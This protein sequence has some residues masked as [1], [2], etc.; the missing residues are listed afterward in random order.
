MDKR[1]IDPETG[2]M[3][4]S[5]NIEDILEAKNIPSWAR[6]KG[7]NLFERVHVGMD[8]VDRQRQQ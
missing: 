2:L 3:E 5:V 1:K 6:P 8:Y 7:T 4:R